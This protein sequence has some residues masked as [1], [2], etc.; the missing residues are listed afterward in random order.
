MTPDDPEWSAQ[1]SLA[2]RRLVAL[3]RVGFD[4]YVESWFARDV[5]GPAL[6]LVGRHARGYHDGISHLMIEMPTQVGKTLH[7]CLFAAQLLGQAPELHVQDCGYGEEFMVQTTGYV[8]AIGRSPGFMSAFPTTRLG[9]PK[10]RELQAQRVER[11]EGRASDTTHQIDTLRLQGRSWKP[12]RGYFRA[13]SVKGAVSGFPG[14][15]MIMEDPYKGWDGEASALS[16]GWNQR[17][18]NFYEGVFRRRSQ[19]ARSCEI[20]AYTPWTDSDIRTHVQ[21]V[22][23]RKGIPYLVIKL[24]MLQ[25]ELGGDYD[26]E[27]EAL[28]RKEARGALRGLARLLRIEPEALRQ[29][30]AAGGP[31]R[32]YDKRP[33]GEALDPKGILPGAKTQAWCESEKASMLMRDFAALWDL[34]PRSDLVDRF[35]KNWWRPWDPTEITISDMEIIAISVDPNGDETEHGAFASMGVWGARRNP[36]PSPARF[37][38]LTYR[39]DELRDRPGYSSFCDMVEKLATRWPE[40]R[41]IIMEATGHGQSASTD[42]NFLSRKAFA[43]RTF[44]FVKPTESKPVRWDLM[45]VPLKHGCGHVPICADAAGRITTSWVSDRDGASADDIRRGDALGFLSELAGSGRLLVCDRTD[46]A[47]QFFMWLREH[48]GTHRAWDKL[49]KLGLDQLGL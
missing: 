19:G 40:A 16:A 31:C 8:S 10:I 18:V 43:G 5:L 9:P 44:V 41:T 35:P 26:F 39:M 11:V 17:L 36:Q 37:P 24:P 48:G 27:R 13:R 49:A 45:E 7:T 33:A 3:G 46:D 15:V 12:T 4:G 34:A 6:E 32:A 14:D 22:W 38:W 47:A 30:I 28:L 23:Q 1:V 21:T 20:H 29:V 42:R 2:R 25:R